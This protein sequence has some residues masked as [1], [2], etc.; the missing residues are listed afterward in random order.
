MLCLATRAGAAMSDW[1]DEAGKTFKGE[2]ADVLGPFAVFRVGG[3]NG[4]TVPWNKFSPEECARFHREISAREAA[5]PGARG[6]IFREL[7]GRVLQMKS[8]KPAPVDVKER[9]E[10]GVIVL[11]SLSNKD[12]AATRLVTAFQLNYRRIQQVF[13]GQMEAVFVGQRMEHDRQLDMARSRRMPWLIADPKHQSKMK[14]LL[15]DIPAE[16]SVIVAMTRN[17]VP[18]LSASGQDEERMRAFM[19][20]LARFM[21]LLEKDNPRNW[22]DRRRYLAAARP[23]EFATGRAEPELM[24]HSLPPDILRKHAVSCVE[25]RME[26]GADGAVG[27]IEV[28][29]TGGVTDALAPGIADALKRGTLFAPAIENGA[30]VAATYAY[31]YDVPPEDLPRAAVAAWLNAEPSREIPIKNWLVL[32]TFKVEQ[33]GFLEVDRVDEN[34][35]SILKSVTADKKRKGPADLRSQMSVFAYDWF[36]PE[37]LMQLRPIAGAKQKIDNEEFT[38]KSFPTVNRAVEL[39]S[40]FGK[41]EYC[42]AYAWTEIEVPQDQTALLGLGSDDGVKVWLNGETLVEKWVQRPLMIDEDVMPLKLKAG[43]NQLLVKVQNIYGEWRFSFRLIA[44]GR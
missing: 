38:W 21:R 43:K 26:V 4:R 3:G 30:P 12:G 35:V 23:V 41:E 28:A 37:Q 15:R 33:Q 18:L 10:P 8:G 22:Q 20:S 27:G 42:Y 9:P 6:A 32:K 17:G 16:A 40:G 11:I 1:K 14:T 39:Q 34:G 7:E 25:A 19:D 36:S 2:P 29:R 13:P 24:G 44:V 5:A 31:R